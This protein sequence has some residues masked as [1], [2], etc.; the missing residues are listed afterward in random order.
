VFIEGEV[1]L[2][3]ELVEEAVNAAPVGRF[4]VAVVVRPVVFVEMPSVALFA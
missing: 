3:P 2:L 4:M 1:A